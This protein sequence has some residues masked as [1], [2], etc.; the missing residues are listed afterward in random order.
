MNAPVGWGSVWD[1][2][3]LCVS[4]MGVRGGGGGVGWGEGRA[5]NPTVRPLSQ[6]FLGSISIDCLVVSV[7]VSV[8][9]CLCV[10]VCGRGNEAGD[11]ICLSFSQRKLLPLCLPVSISLPLSVRLRM[12]TC[13]RP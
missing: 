8:D 12:S 9:V 2:G 5:V 10:H 4:E 6:K 13:V 11:Y 1:G 7:F 3:G